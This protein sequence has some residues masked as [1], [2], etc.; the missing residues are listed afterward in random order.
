MPG[1]KH[2]PAPRP[3][4]PPRA[5]ASAAKRVAA[6]P[7]VQPSSVASATNA[8]AASPHPTDAFNHSAQDA[9]F[10]RGDYA[11]LENLWAKALNADKNVRVVITPTYTSG[12]RP[13][14]KSAC[15]TGLM[16][17]VFVRVSP[18]NR[19][20]QAMQDEVENLLQNIGRILTEDAEYPS[21]PT[22]LFAEVG[23]N[24][25]GRPCSKT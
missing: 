11:R 18:M 7:R 5:V 9:N 1:E 17:F 25:V 16:A 13:R 2:P 20:G 21:E 19:E 6:E 14:L 3:K 10:N 8:T 23:R 12:S 24:V 4:Q 22:L 15:I